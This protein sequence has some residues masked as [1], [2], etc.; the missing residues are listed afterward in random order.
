MMY[1]KPPQ[2]N[3]ND[4]Y[5]PLNQVNEEKSTKARVMFKGSPSD[6]RRDMRVAKETGLYDRATEK[7]SGKGRVYEITFK[8]EGQF[9]RFM[10]QFEVDL[11]E[12]P[13]KEGV[14]I[15]EAC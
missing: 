13:L 3:H 14:K 5:H 8:S 15:D 12:Y 1:F 2:N 4:F 6:A 7:P 10:S 11:M 9:R